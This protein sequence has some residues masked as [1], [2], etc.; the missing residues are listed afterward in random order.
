MC[1]ET[2]KTGRQGKNHRAIAY[3]GLGLLLSSSLSAKGTCAQKGFA[4]FVSF[5]RRK[6]KVCRE[7]G[8]WV[9]VPREK[10]EKTRTGGKKRRKA[11]VKISGKKKKRWRL[12]WQP[13]CASTVRALSRDRVPSRTCSTIASLDR[14]ARRHCRVVTP[15]RR[16]VRHHRQRHLR[17]S[18]SPTMRGPRERESEIPRVRS[19][20]SFWSTTAMP[21]VLFKVREGR[22]HCH[23]RRL[24]CCRR[25]VPSQTAGILKNGTMKKRQTAF[26]R[27]M[28]RPTVEMALCLPHLPT[29]ALRAAE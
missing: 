28:G 11:Q 23:R 29:T 4:V 10:T 19:P 6:K 18:G 2:P 15:D 26:Y 27:A 8:Q 24:P 21:T 25:V 16:P 20:A 3:T 17:R 5:S 1:A 7:F 12:F 9:R 14:A 13:K 22:H